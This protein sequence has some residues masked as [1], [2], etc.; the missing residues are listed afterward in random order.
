[1]KTAPDKWGTPITRDLSGIEMLRKLRGVK[2]FD[3]FPES[4]KRVYLQVA[5]CFPGIQVWAFGSRVVGHYVDKR[6]GEEIRAARKIAGIKDKIESDFDF[7][8]E[9]NAIQV[10]ELPPNTERVR[11]R[12][13]ESEKIA[14]PIYYVELG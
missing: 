10:G 1:M 5:K 4:T 8:V 14:I 6:D 3:Q 13:P 12:I 2:S 7:L 11:C 9:P